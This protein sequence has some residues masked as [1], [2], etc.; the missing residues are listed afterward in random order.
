MGYG[1]FH[2]V[3]PEPVGSAQVLPGRRAADA[4]AAAT[5]WWIIS[6]VG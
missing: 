4:S 5:A 6:D 3:S 2:R 1:S